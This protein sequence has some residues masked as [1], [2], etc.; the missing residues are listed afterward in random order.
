MNQT[1]LALQ[2]QQAGIINQT[3]AGQ[4]QRSASPWWLQILLAIAA[5]IASLLIIGSFIGPVLA[6]ADHNAVRAVIALLLISAAIWLAVKPLEFLQQMS[7]A[8]ALAGQGM[9]VYVSYDLFN[10]DVA[11]YSCAVIAVLLLFSPLTPLH[12]RLS[13]SIAL[14][15]LLSLITSPVVLSVSGASLTAIAVLLWY[16]RQHWARWRY[17]QTVKS[18]L[19]VATLAALLLAISGQSLFWFDNLLWLENTAAYASAFY[20]ISGAIMFISSVFWLSRQATVPSRLALLS[21]A[22]LLSIVLYSASGLLI[23]AALMLACF[24]GCS[25][26][27]YGLCLLSMLFTTSQFYYSLNLTLLYKAGILALSGLVLLAA[28]LL[29]QRYQR[30]FA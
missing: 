30:R 2:L 9:L 19:E 1:E 15:C 27:W 13:I 4:L 29:L 28:W 8:V 7:V 11:R 10:D 22:L 6:L 20:S 25:R 18:M 5:W 12:Q 21:M 23:S 16:N 14:A 24:Y 26:L 17:A 3:T